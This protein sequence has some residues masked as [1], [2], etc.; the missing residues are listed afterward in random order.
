ML[1]VYTLL[2][3]TVLSNFIDTLAK[4]EDL[5]SHSRTHHGW[6]LAYGYYSAKFILVCLNLAQFF[7]DFRRSFCCFKISRLDLFSIHSGLGY[8]AI[9]ELVSKLDS[10]S[11][12]AELKDNTKQKNKS[13]QVIPDY[14]PSEKAKSQ[15]SVKEKCTKTSKKHLNLSRTKNPHL[16][17]ESSLNI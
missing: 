14:L 11:P 3:I 10:S 16:V 7:E 8:Q 15:V 17:A 5:Q 4:I 9:Q 2:L 1:D 12:S 6:G 13:Y